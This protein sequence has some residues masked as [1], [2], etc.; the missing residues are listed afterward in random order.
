MKSNDQ[1]WLNQFKS[2]MKKL[3]DS[4]VPKVPDQGQL[5]STLSKFKAE[6]KRAFK[7]ELALF[8]L[9]AFIIL[10]SYI[11]IALKLTTLF[12]WIQGLV[13]LAIP[14]IIIAEKKRVKKR[15]SD[16]GF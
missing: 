14:T 3:D 12:I 8:L 10:T 1:D 5:M 7:R 6:R 2:D 11:M 15:V 16:Y 4:Y 9:T 13:L